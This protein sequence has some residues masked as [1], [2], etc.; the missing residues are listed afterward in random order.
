MD[1]VFSFYLMERFL[2]EQGILEQCPVILA[3][4]HEINDR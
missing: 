2:Y 1:F 3:P 4:G